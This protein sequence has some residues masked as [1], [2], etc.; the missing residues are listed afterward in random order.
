[1]QQ[2]KRVL[3]LSLVLL[4]STPLFAQNQKRIQNFIIS[5]W[6]EYDHPG[7]LVIFNGEV[8]AS[9][10]PLQVEY[11][12]PDRAKFALVAGS[13]DTTANKVIP[14]PIQDTD[15]GKVISFTAVNPSFHVEFYFNPFNTDEAHRQ[16]DY[17]FKSNLPIDSL[18]VDY[19]QPMASENFKP[20]VQTDH[21]LQDSH[22]ITYFR[23]HYNNVKAGQSIA[24]KAEYDNPSGNLTNDMLQQQLGQSGGT[25]GGG[26]SGEGGGSQVQMQSPTNNNSIWI[27]GIV[28]VLVLIVLYFVTQSRGKTPREDTPAS[29]EQAIPPEEEKVGGTDADAKF[30]INCG[31]SL[32]KDAKFCTKC[33]AEQP[34]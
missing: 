16:Y 33:G 11:P 3:M 20:G 7:V 25:M 22:G 31:A 19:Q 32:P 8:P 10:L 5:V 29:P 15:N 18:I 13:T 21:Q 9:A 12:V 34:E 26:M 28:I 30:C 6:P 23:K 24:I 27:L 17:T 14:V 1:M 4:I 2:L